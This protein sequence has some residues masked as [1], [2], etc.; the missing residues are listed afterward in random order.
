MT[1]HRYTTILLI[2]ILL[3]SAALRLYG[4]LW[5]DDLSGYPHPDERHLANTMG[6]LTIPRPVNWEALLNDP[7]HSLLN[8][9]KLVPGTEQHYDLAY[10]TLP[11]YLYRA[12]AVLLAQSTGNPEIDSY[13]FYRVIGRAI[14]ALFSLLTVLLVYLIGRRTFGTPIG[15]LAAALLGACVLHIQLSHFMTVDLLM[16]ALL[17]AG[18]LFAVRF[19]QDG[20]TIDAFWTGLLMGLTMA[21]KFNG[22]TLIAGVVTA[23]GVAWL[24]GKRTLKDLLSFC[25]PLTFIGWVLAFSAFEYYA[26]RDPYTYAHAIGIQ[27]KMVSGE[28]DWPYTRQYVNTEP[29]LFQTR[30]L[31]I[32]GMGWPLGIAAI[33]GVIVAMVGLAVDMWRSGKVQSP[34]EHKEEREHSGVLRASIG[35]VHACLQACLQ[36]WAADRRRAGMLVLL[37]WAVPFYLYTARLEVKFLRYMLPMTPVL[38]LFAADLLWR[39][40]GLISEPQ[41]SGDRRSTALIAL[42]WVL[43]A[44]V[45]LPT[46]LW[47]LAYM[48]VYAQEHPWQ[49]A[50]RW[51]YE[52]APAGS[53]YTWEAWGDPLPT[54]L[55]DLSLSRERAGY[56]DVRMHIYHDMPPQDKVQHIAD[57]L[58]QA[59]YVVLSTPRL[60]LSVARL[61]WRYPVE[62]RYYELL[63]GEQLGYDLVAKF[64]AFPGLNIPGM[65]TFEINDLAA[66]QSFFDYEHPLVLIFR[67]THDLSDQEWQSLFAEQ[68]ATRP[69]TT[70]EGD[71]SPVQLPI[72]QEPKP[73]QLHG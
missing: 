46:A 50:S 69:E 5:D 32:W 59:D 62:I 47:A 13:P 65:E 29:Y 37:G 16:S 48:R 39:L 43:I 14:T 27:A 66:D 52:H 35:K 19:A 18:L 25:L 17:T 12:A 57:S 31:V 9:R 36:P 60:Y 70:R 64:T 3:A 34:R 28:T 51:F 40:G 4:L 41:R 72:P 20:R 21:T 7:D 38:C 42:R 6:R 45:L 56:G 22:I 30:N 1:K 55:P 26:V 24:S 54:N 11:V 49:A 63:F 73:G 33:A 58:R 2:T 68:L 23:Y 67:K 15:L 10:G 71:E 8:P 44:I 61:P 53:A